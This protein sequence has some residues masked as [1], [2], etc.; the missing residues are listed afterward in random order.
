MSE[1][2][3]LEE[4]IARAIC[5]HRRDR[6]CGNPRFGPCRSGECNASRGLLLSENDESGS[7]ARAAIDAAERAG[8]RWS[9]QDRTP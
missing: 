9:K 2:E 1:R 5:L 8:F 4:I 6:A 7:Q 3:K